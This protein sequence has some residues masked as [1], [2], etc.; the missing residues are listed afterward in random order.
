M[1]KSGCGLV[2]MSLVLSKHDEQHLVQHHLSSD[3][4]DESRTA[5]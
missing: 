2:Q 3:P 1:A 5:N 4:R